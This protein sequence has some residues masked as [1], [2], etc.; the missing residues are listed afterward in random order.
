MTDPYRALGVS[1]DADDD[2]IKKAFKKLAKKYHPDLNDSPE[3]E[4]KF[5]Q[6]NAAY[7]ILGDA[8]KRKAWDTFGEAST[9]PGFNADQ[10]RAWGAGGGGFGGFGG[11]GDM[12]DILESLFGGGAG[13]PRGPRKGA[14]LRV[15]LQVDPMLAIRGGE[16]T[17]RIGRPDGT[18]DN[19]KVRIPAGVSDGGK[20]RLRG[21][22]HPP[23]G[24]GPCGDLI[25]ILQIPDHPLLKRVDDNLELEVPITVG[26]AVRGGSITVPTPTGDVKVTVPAGITASKR[27]RLRGRGVQTKQPGDLYLSLRIVLPDAEAEG[28]AEAAEMLEGAYE[29]VRGKLAL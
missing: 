26:E 10:A 1:R 11:G 24:G 22:G 25:V 14:D 18:S 29:D 3:A 9:R 23:P 6:A 16:T 15:R 27:L 17:V 21:Q 2:A 13:R 20:L 4:E 8:D 28:V 5:K 19:L 12:S 7:A